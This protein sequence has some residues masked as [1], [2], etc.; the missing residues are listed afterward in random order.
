MSNK[1]ICKRQSVTEYH[2]VENVKA[3]FNDSVVIEYYG[4][5]SKTTSYYSLSEIKNPEV[6]TSV[7]CTDIDAVKMID[8]ILDFI[9]TKYMSDEEK[10]KIIKIYMSKLTESQKLIYITENREYCDFIL[11]EFA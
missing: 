8:D 7:T 6:L 4:L 1:L 9:I 11:N 10:N 3:I 5:D 2:D